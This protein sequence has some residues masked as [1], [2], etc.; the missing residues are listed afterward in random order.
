[1]RRDMNAVQSNRWRWRCRST[2]SR[3]NSFPLEVQFWGLS[4]DV[5]AS[6]SSRAPSESS[7]NGFLRRQ[8]R[9]WTNTQ[10]HRVFFLTGYFTVSEWAFLFRSFLTQS[11]FQRVHHHLVDQEVPPI[12]S[13]GEDHRDQLDLELYWR[14]VTVMVSAI[15]KRLLE[16]EHDRN[17]HTSG[18]CARLPALSELPGC[19]SGG[20]TTAPHCSVE[21]LAKCCTTYKRAE[22]GCRHN[23]EHVMAMLLK[24]IKMKTTC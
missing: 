17:Q 13:E 9:S 2:P 1:M 15:R 5:S 12:G 11:V 21:N 23:H 22:V 24:K 7:G 8:L 20:L 10:I 4:C 3:T 14:F 19:S 16:C 18:F 6:R